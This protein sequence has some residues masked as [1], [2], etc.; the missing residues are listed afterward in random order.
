[1]ADAWRLVHVLVVPPQRLSTPEVYG[2][3]RFDLTVKKPFSTMVQCALSN[4]S[5]GELAKGLWNDL[6][7]E[8]IRRCPVIARIHTHLR[9]VGC[10]GTL[11]SGSGPAVFGLCANLDQANE[12]ARRLSVISRPHSWTIGIVQTEH[13]S[14]AATPSAP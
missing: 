10:L 5:L 4:G 3:L 12:L 6:E 11:M 8:A 14:P 7:P 13:P 9:E 2:A 1:V